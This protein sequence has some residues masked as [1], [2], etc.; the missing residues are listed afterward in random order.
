M[1][2][3]STRPAAG[4]RAATIHQQVHQLRSAVA[5]LV[6]P[7]DALRIIRAMSEDGAKACLAVAIASERWSPAERAA[8]ALPP[9]PDYAAIRAENQALLDEY[10]RRVTTAQD[11]D[12]TFQEDAA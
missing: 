12:V 5:D 3:T 9:E 1:T 2:T 4:T 6:H 7:G 11:I 10:R 8:M